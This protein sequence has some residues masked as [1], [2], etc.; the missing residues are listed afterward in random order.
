MTKEATFARCAGESIWILDNASAEHSDIRWML[1]EVDNLSLKEIRRIQS[2]L[3]LLNGFLGG[4]QRLE[5]FGGVVVHLLAGFPEG[6]DLGIPASAWLDEERT[7]LREFPI[8][9]P[10]PPNASFWA[11][12]DAAELYRQTEQERIRVD[13]FG[14]VD[15]ACYETGTSDMIVSNSFHRLL[16]L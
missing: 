10:K 16:P 11:V 7:N 4:W 1:I 8:V 9:C 15:V 12:T 3:K 5:H 14:T 13:T 2:D 6:Y